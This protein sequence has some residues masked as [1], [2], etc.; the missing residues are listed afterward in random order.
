M[1][2]ATCIPKGYDHSKDY[3]GGFVEEWNKCRHE[4]NDDYKAL[5]KKYF[6]STL[7]W[8]RVYFRETIGPILLVPRE[9]HVQLQSVLWFLKET[10]AEQQK[11]GKLATSSWQDENDETC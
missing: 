1:V 4:H 2:E 8:D 11:E 5:V 3:K 10:E 7:V 6:E 9:R